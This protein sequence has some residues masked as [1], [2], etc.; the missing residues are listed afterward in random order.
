[1]TEAFNIDCMVGMAK[2]PDGYFELAIVEFATLTPKYLFDI[3]ENIKRITDRK[4]RG[5]HG[6]RGLNY[7]GVRVL[8]IR[9][10]VALR[11][12]IRRWAQAVKGTGENHNG[13]ALDP[14]ASEG[15]EGLHIQ[16]QEAW[17]EEH[18]EVRGRGNRFIRFGLFGHTEGGLP[19][20]Q[21]HAR[22]HQ[23]TCRPSTGDV[24]RREGD[25]RLSESDC[26]KRFMQSIGNIRTSWNPCFN[27]QPNVAGG[28][29][30]L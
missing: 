14:T 25:G 8:P 18:Q 2:Y 23:H 16:R 15:V 20:K 24:L 10:G 6:L 11:R 27:G 29:Q 22:D 13:R 19:E 9:A 7:E 1:M 28:V 21:R 3:H 5:V 30:P 12:A 26:V 17:E 4:S